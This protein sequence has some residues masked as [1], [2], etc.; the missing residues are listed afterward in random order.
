MP[1]KRCLFSF[2]FFHKSLAFFSFL[3]LLLRFLVFVGVAVR[4]WR[5]S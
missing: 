5:S 4:A 1:L 2:L 3:V